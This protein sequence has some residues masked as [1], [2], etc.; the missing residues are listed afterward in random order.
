MV[1]GFGGHDNRDDLTSDGAVSSDNAEPGEDRLVSGEASSGT[2]DNNER[3]EKELVKD[4]NNDKTDTELK[5]DK[6]EDKVN[7]KEETP[8]SLKKKLEQAEADIEKKDK[9]IAEIKDLLQRRQADF[10][11]YKKRIAKTHEDFK[12]LAV[13]D[14]ALDVIIINDDLLR[15]IEASSTVKNGESLEQ[16]HSSFVDGVSM[17]SKMIEEMLKK[18]S[19]VE[20][21]SLHQSFDP[22]YNE[23]VEIIMSEEVREDTITKIYQKGFKLDDLVVRSAKV[24]VARPSLSGGSSGN[25]DGNGNSGDE[26]ETQEIV[27]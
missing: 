2:I 4:K 14:F 25:T 27:N 16:C 12:K 19:I 21:D 13:K 9:E 5:K 8:D 1:T 7:V 3:G 11:N 17:I 22:Q 10:E 15:A 24:Q 6:T 20:I 26:R 18:Y 23:A